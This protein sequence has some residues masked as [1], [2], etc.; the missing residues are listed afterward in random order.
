MQV[1][2]PHQINKRQKSKIRLLSFMMGSFILIFAFFN[3]VIWFN[4]FSNLGSFSE[5]KISYLR[6]FPDLLNNPSIINA[7]AMTALVFAIFFFRVSAKEDQ[8][9]FLSILG[10][11]GNLV[12]IGAAIWLM[13]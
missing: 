12:F 8:L 1:I 4:K 13:L 10:I 7:M 6:H 3:L 11:M 2:R 9:K 5:A